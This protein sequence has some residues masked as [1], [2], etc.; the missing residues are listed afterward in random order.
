MGWKRHNYEHSLAAKGVK[1]KSNYQSPKPKI[2]KPGDKVL[3][4][5]QTTFNKGEWKEVT[6]KKLIY[7]DGILTHYE[8]KEFPGAFLAHDI[9]TLK[10]AEAYNK[11]YN[12]K[13]VKILKPQLLDNFFGGL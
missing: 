11:K 12:G 7:T 6:I 5:T 10:G 8:Y 13:Q 9:E 1:T 4:A 2:Y 3:I